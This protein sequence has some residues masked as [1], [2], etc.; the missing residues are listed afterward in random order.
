MVMTASFVV[1]PS[2]PRRMFPVKHSAN[3]MLAALGRWRRRSG[4]KAVA[5]PRAPSPYCFTSGQPP[6]AIGR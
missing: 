2:D 1:Q 4:G 3:T 5:A 6:S